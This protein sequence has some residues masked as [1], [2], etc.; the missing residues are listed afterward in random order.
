MVCPRYRLLTIQE[1]PAAGTAGAVLVQLYSITSTCH[2]CS[3]IKLLFS[4]SHRALQTCH[5]KPL[6]SYVL[7]SQL[8]SWQ[9]SATPCSTQQ[10][11]P[12]PRATGRLTHSTKLVLWPVVLSTP[13]RSDV[14]YSG[15]WYCSAGGSQLCT[16]LNCTT[17]RG[18]RITPGWDS[19]KQPP[20][21]SQRPP[22]IHSPSTKMPSRGGSVTLLPDSLCVT[23]NGECTAQLACWSK[24]QITHMKS[25][26]VSLAV[27]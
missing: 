25:L 11:V 19:C 3:M 13:A 10:S 8:S 7:T 2:M 6:K 17:G 9:S 5:S 4:K 23:C 12:V 21:L 27:H 14:L 20:V 15:H 16:G 24:G 22:S 26:Q 1:A 18:A